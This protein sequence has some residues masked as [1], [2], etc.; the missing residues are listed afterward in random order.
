MREHQILLQ[1]VVSH[2]VVAGIWT[3]DL[4]KNKQWVLLTHEPSL[5][6]Q[7]QTDLKLIEMVLP[8]S[9]C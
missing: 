8:P 9:E 2:Y 3:Q 6:P 5:H 7:E 4:Q 1:M